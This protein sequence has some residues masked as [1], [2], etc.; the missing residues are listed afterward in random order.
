MLIRL[1][2][3]PNVSFLLMLITAIACMGFVMHFVQNEFIRLSANWVSMN[4]TVAN[5][6][7]LIRWKSQIN[8]EYVLS[9]VKSTISLDIRQWYTYS[10]S[11]VDMLSKLPQ[12]SS[13][14]VEH[15]RRNLLVPPPTDRK[16][17]EA[18]DTSKGQAKKVLQYFG[19]KSHGIFIECGANDGNFLSNTLWLETANNWTG[20]LIEA[21]Q[22]NFKGLMAAKRNA[23]LM[24]TCLSLTQHPSMITMEKSGAWARI[25]GDT[26]VS[27]PTSVQ[28]MPLFSILLAINQ[29]IDYFSL[30]I[31][32]HELDVLRTVPFDQIDVKMW[33]I[34]HSNIQEGGDKLMDFMILNG[35]EALSSTPEEQKG[36]WAQ[37][38][39]IFVKK[40]FVTDFNVHAIHNH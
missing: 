21:E 23:W 8:R 38:D 26:H 28:C 20:V 10:K 14:L 27:D 12:D 25:K 18:K 29:T 36:K 30:D 5:L 33:S 7:G 11:E 9:F 37:E 4:S 34:E 16:V 40:D 1:F 31:E 6:D 19:N 22:N 2:Y 17:L 15:I 13:E 3:K 39:F 32:G 24:P 35:Y